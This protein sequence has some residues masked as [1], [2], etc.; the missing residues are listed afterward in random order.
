MGSNVN[1]NL[2]FILKLTYS[3]HHVL[4]VADKQKY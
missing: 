1:K 4:S 3:F 2:T